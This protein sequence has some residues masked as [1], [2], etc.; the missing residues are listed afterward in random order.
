MRVDF[1]H[2]FK[3]AIPFLFLVFV[4]LHSLSKKNGSALYHC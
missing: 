4:F 1:S 2:L 3:N